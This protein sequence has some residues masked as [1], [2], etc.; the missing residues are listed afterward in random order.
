M[1]RYCAVAAQPYQAI[2]FPRTLGCSRPRH[3]VITS[4]LEE[5]PSSFNLHVLILAR[6]SIHHHSPSSEA[7]ATA[8]LPDQL[9]R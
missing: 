9:P 2:P 1:S 7:L 6:S 5:P 3:P 4:H 8:F